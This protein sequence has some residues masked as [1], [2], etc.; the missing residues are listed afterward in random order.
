MVGGRLFS[1]DLDFWIAFCYCVTKLC[2]RAHSVYLRVQ[3]ARGHDNPSMTNP[4]GHHQI[5]LF[6]A[7]RADGARNTSG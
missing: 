2:V 5:V 4:V 7:E 1:I 6:D 3:W